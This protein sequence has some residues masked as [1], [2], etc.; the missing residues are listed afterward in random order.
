MGEAV[1][2]DRLGHFVDRFNHAY[3]GVAPRHGTGQKFLAACVNS[4]AVESLDQASPGRSFCGII[5]K[6]GIS[7]SCIRR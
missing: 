1:G 4:A 7:L 2:G 3:K 6:S 5:K